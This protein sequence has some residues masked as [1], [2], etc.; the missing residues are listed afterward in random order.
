MGPNTA[1]KLIREHGSLEGVVDF[2]EKDPKSRYKIP[3]DWPFQDARDLFF[4][5][6]V[7]A[8]DDPL[9][10]FKWDKPDME[11]LVQF[12]VAEKG[13]SEDRVRAGGKRL[14]KNLSSAQQGRLDGFFKVIPKTEEER[15][16]LKRKNDEKNEEKRKKAKDEKR[17]KA[18]AKAKPRGAA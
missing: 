10:D 4:E 7:R 9:C 2:I 15:A 3:E 5:P 1:L 14:E 8:A 12:L 11:G 18:K 13:F 16:A 6:D 17:E